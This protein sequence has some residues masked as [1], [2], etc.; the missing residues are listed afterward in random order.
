MADELSYAERVLE[1][2]RARRAEAA[3]WQQVQKEEKEKRKHREMLVCLW[4]TLGIFFGIPLLICLAPGMNIANYIMLAGA[5]ILQV[6]V[7]PI[8]WLIV[9]FPLAYYFKKRK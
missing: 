1:K 3:R 5:L 4:V 7:L 9:M 2:T 6:P 8:L